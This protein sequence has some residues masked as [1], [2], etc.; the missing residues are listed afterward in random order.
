[1]VPAL[2][3]VT[4]CLTMVP[5]LHGRCLGKEICSPELVLRVRKGDG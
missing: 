2:L 5:H 3:E 1:M 4:P